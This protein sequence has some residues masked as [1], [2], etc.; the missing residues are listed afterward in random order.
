M[1]VNSLL[2]LARNV[3]PAKPGV[4]PPCGCNDDLLMELTRKYQGDFP[5]ITTDGSF[6]AP[7]KAEFTAEVI[8]HLTRQVPFLKLDMLWIDVGSPSKG[9]LLCQLSKLDGS[10]YA[11]AIGA[12]FE[13]CVDRLTNS[14]AIARVPGLQCARRLILE[15][16]KLRRSALT[17][18]PHCLCPFIRSLVGI[19]RQSSNR[20]IID[21][22][23]GAPLTTP[24]NVVPQER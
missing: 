7:C 15:L 5:G 2:C 3:H 13:F 12:A 16:R 19:D 1:G 6:A 20:N 24:I 23:V 17:L 11:A 21:S 22:I 8:A 4:Y 9:K 10:S 18:G 14:L